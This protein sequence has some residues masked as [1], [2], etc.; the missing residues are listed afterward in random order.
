MST[1]SS[2][3]NDPAYWQQRAEETRALADQLE[4]PAARQTLVEIALSYEQLAAI[5]ATRLL[6][7]EPE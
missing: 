1:L 5:A 7:S 4:D 6:A 3:V 2:P